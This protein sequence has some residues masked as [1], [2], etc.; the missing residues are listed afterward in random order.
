MN[1]YAVTAIVGFL[2]AIAIGATLIVKNPEVTTLTLIPLLA[3]LIALSAAM[4][5]TLI[6]TTER[7]RAQ[8]AAVRRAQEREDMPFK[9][10]GGMH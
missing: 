4:A 10:C 7:Q 5:G 2:A 8:A 1:R 3:F 9:W 6:Y